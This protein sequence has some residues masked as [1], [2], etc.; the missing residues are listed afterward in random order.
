MSIWRIEKCHQ[1]SRVLYERIFKHTNPIVLKMMVLI[2][3]SDIDCFSCFTYKPEVSNRN[4]QK[5]KK[6]KQR[7]YRPVYQHFA[8]TEARARECFICI[9]MSIACDC[10][11]HVPSAHVKNICMHGHVHG[12]T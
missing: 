2:K 10:Q 1:L 3:V 8:T 5:N 9:Y 12:S 6:N 4:I 11:R 7:Y